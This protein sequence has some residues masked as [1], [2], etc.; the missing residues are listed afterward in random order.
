MERQRKREIL[1]RRK[2]KERERVE[3]LSWDQPSWSDRIN[4]GSNPK[5]PPKNTKTTGGGLGLWVWGWCGIS[6]KMVN[7]KIISPPPLLYHRLLLS[8]SSLIILTKTWLTL[9]SNSLLHLLPHFS[10]YKIPTTKH[11]LSLCSQPNSFSRQFSLFV[12]PFLFFALFSRLRHLGFILFIFI[13]FL[14]K[15]GLLFLFTRR[16]LVLQ[17]SSNN[18]VLDRSSISHFSLLFWD[19]PV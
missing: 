7:K 1:E 6:K 3:L 17:F 12:S 16:R 5:N 8:L 18:K 10:F 19:F 11:H 13:F 15:E 9:I 4:K 2:R 14:L